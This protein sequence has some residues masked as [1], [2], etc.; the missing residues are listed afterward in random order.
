MW[1]CNF[2][3]DFNIEVYGDTPYCKAPKEVLRLDLLVLAGIK[4][5]HT[6]LPCFQILRHA[7]SQY[8]AKHPHFF[9][10]SQVSIKNNISEH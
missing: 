3:L 5:I 8:L 1:F 10:P 6:H 4:Y 9:L 2:G 7:C